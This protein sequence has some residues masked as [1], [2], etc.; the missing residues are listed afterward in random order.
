MNFKES[1][2]WIKEI[3]TLIDSVCREMGIQAYLIGAQAKD[4]YLAEFGISP[5][6]KTMDFDFAIMMPDIKTY[7]KIIEK[8]T[9]TG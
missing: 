1:T 8:L 3:F 5:H 2:P 7:D 9:K 4:F 6:I